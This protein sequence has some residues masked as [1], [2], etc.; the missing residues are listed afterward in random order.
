V[1]WSIKFNGKEIRNPLL[2]AV[3]SLF[4]LLVA[5][6]VIVVTVLLLPVIIPVHFLLRAVG[7]RGFAQ[8]VNDKLDI[9]MGA[10]AFKQIN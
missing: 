10:K 1:G 3:A 4:T 9:N 8:I 5:G 7:R 2:R 6:M